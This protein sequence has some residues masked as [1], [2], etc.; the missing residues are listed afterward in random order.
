ME[1]LTWEVEVQQCDQDP[2]R[3]RMVYPYDGKYGYNEEG[4][5]DVQKSYDIE[6]VIPDA[7]HV[8]IRPQKIG[9]DWGYGMFGIASMAGYR[10]ENGT[11]IDS[12]GAEDFGVL[13]NGEIS[14][15]AQKLLTSMANYDGGAW[16]YANN[17]SAFKLVLPDAVPTSAPAV[18]KAAAPSRKAVRNTGKPVNEKATGN[19]GR[20]I[21]K[22]QLSRAD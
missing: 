21:V 6:I 2:T 14:F 9:I 4:A 17:N 22:A 1:N 15:G 10:I 20:H 7:N 12:I 16:Y 19:G 8:Y 3:I 11:G 13:E 5:W 18:K